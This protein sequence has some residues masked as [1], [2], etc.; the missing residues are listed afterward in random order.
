LPK[1]I[2]ITEARKRMGPLFSEVVNQHRPVLIGRREQVGLLVGAEEAVSLLAS[3]EFHSRVF[4]EDGAVSF[5]VPE[6]AVYGRAATYEDAADDLV[7]EVREYIDEYWREIDRYRQAPN[8]A[9][10]F[11]YL[12]RAY[13][14]DQQGRLLDVLLAEPRDEGSTW[15]RR[16]EALAST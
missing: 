10:H 2:P 13:L 9:S 4:F 1:T 3:Y 15:E 11:P 12:M 14:A 16:E 7:E 5:W 8:R 6:L